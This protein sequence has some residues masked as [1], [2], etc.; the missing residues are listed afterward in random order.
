MLTRTGWLRVICAAGIASACGGSESTSSQ[1]N[2]NPSSSGNEQPAV[3]DA[4]PPAMEEST[5]RDAGAPVAQVEPPA[6]VDAGPPPET[7]PPPAGNGRPTMSG[8]ARDQYRAGL[9]AA[10]TGNLDQ[11]RAAFEGALSADPR[12]YQAA[13]NAGIIAERQGQDSQADSLYQR[14]LSIVPDYELAVVARARLLLRARRSTE[15]VTMAADIAR[16][17]PNNYTVRAEYARLMVVA[18]RYN[19]AIEEGRRILRQDERNVGAKLAIAEAYRAQ[20]RLDMALAIVNDVIHG[21]GEPEQPDNGPG[22]GDARAHYLR[23]LLRVE[24]ERNVPGAI[25]SFQR[26]VEL[27][28]QFS[29]ARNNLGVYLLQA[30]NYQG[31][32]EHLRA[33]TLL[34]PSWARAHLNLGDALR[35]TRDY[36]GATTELQRAQQLDASI[37][38][39]HYNYGRLYSEQAREIASTGLDNLNRKIQ[40]LQQAQAAFTRFRDN[41]GPG[42]ATHPRHDDVEQ[43]LTRLQSLVERTTRARDREQRRSRSG[44]PA[45][46]SSATPSGGGDAGAPAAP[47][48]GGSSGS[49]DAGAAH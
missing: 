30:G 18:Q 22:V 46:G 26:A 25:L 3:R 24:V 16:R 14:S 34:S 29:E 45:A 20:G 23:G 41:L 48:G 1:T 4:G 31:A 7:T 32:I 37:V 9:Q 6:V 42:Y 5:S 13:Y 10:Q 36:P 33:A 27:D 8:G 47:S 38:E 43:Q 11:A 15:A 12:A 19:E 44:T 28:P 40:L 21:S 35:A 39:V 2:R 49:A 17:F